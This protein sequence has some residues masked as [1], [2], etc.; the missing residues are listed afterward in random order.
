M[1]RY[2]DVGTWLYLDSLAAEVS[3][4]RRLVHESERFVAYQPYASTAP[5]ETWI[6]PRAQEASFVEATDATLDELSGVVRAV[7]GGL[8]TALDDPDYNLMIH[9]APPSDERK[10]YFVWHIRILPRLSTPAGFELATGMAINAS[11][12]EQT[13]PILRDA[14]AAELMPC[15]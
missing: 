5:H 1:Q 2:D 11:L 12:P 3:D 10:Q 7:L 8:R 4:G 13:T 9:S 15:T 14:V 6:M